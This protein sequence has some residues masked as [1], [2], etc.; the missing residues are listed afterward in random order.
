MIHMLQ[1]GVEEEGG[2]SLGLAYELKVDNEI[3][4][5][6]GTTNQASDGWYVG[7]TKDLVTGVW[8]GGDGR[9]IHYESWV[10]GQ[11]GRTAR[12]IFEAFMLKVY[13]A[14]SLPYEKGPF[15]RPLSGLDM[16]LDCGKYA[17]GDSDSIPVEDEEPWDPNAF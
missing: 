16:N 8:G 10:M 15:K 3:G 11:G 17:T 1:G 13:A 12:P 4:G 2:T 6:T 14:E 9:S 7:V 5:K